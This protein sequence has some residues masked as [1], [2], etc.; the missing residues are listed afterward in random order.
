MAEKQILAALQIESNEVRLLVGEV[1]NTRL[2]ILMQEVVPCKGLDGI[3]IVDQKAVAQA[4]KSAVNNVTSH[5]GTPI[6]GVLLSIPAYRFKRETRSFS[7]VIDAGDRKITYGDI[8][9]I[10][11]KALSVNVG[12]DVEVINITSNKYK[13]NGIV[14]RKMPVGEQCDILEADVDLLCCDKMVTYDYAAVVEQAGLSIIE[15]CMDNY[16]VAKEA[17]LF[18]Q[19]MRNYV[20]SIQ[21]EKQHTMFSLIY[22]GKI[23]SSENDTIGYASLATPITEKYGLPEKNALKLLMKYARLDQKDFNRRPL[24]S[25][26]INGITNTINDYELYEVV[27]EPADFL[28]RDYRGLCEQILEQENVTV[29][30]SGEGTEIQGIDKVLAD[31]FNKPV[32]CYYP[33]TL[34]ARAGKW[35]V[36][37]GMF[38]AYVDQ[39]GVR[40][41]DES[42]VDLNAYEAHLNTVVEEQVHEE[43]FTARLKN[44]LFNNQKNG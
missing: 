37:L 43:G 41:K 12:G 16:A 4:V 33:E 36:C 8:Q 1:L 3:R 2:N 15:V 39:N 28:A 17:A 6:T 44:I 20:L 14:Y 27:K 38:Y 24:Y 21:L 9:D 23:I 40:P 10:Y 34:G 13:T 32:K 25:W 31:K 22:D 5:L 18:E 19:T 11:R 42:S 29:I 30:I 26:T 35:T 7:K